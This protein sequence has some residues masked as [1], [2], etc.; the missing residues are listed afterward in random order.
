MLENELQ[1]Q[2]QIKSKFEEI[3]R[4]VQKAFLDIRRNL[5]TNT[6][7][8]KQQEAIRTLPH[9]TITKAAKNRL[10]KFPN[11]C[12]MDATFV[13]GTIFAA[14]ADTQ[15]LKY[16]QFEYIRCRPTEKTKTVMFDC[17]WWL[18]IEGYDIDITFRQL[19]TV[20]KGNEGKVIFEIHPLIDS[21]DYIYE[22]G[23]A[24]TAEFHA[25]FTNFIIENYFN[26]KR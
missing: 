26:R 8:K 19:K 11:D 3:A 10:K 18:R 12:C 16:G 13:L 9:D 15:G 5:K 7:S 6:L 14:Y 2:Q 22:S 20:Q 24:G 25:E 17:H 1:Q 21:D 23:K 4:L